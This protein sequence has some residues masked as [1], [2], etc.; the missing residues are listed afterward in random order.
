MNMRWRQ[1]C[2]LAGAA[3]LSLLVAGCPTAARRPPAAP[4]APAPAAP[5]PQAPPQAQPQAGDADMQRSSA[6][7]ERIEALEGVETA[8][9]V[10]S[11]EEAYVG[12][13]AGAEWARRPQANETLERRV[14]E[15]ALESPLGIKRAYVTTKPELYQSIFNITEG[16]RAGQP[17][18]RF[19]SELN[20]LGGEI[21]PVSLP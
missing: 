8:W 4:P 1:V 16:L 6:L 20:K 18:A 14:A 9:V 10:V 12:V 19:Q 3:T 5:G 11:G 17:M 2:F 13:D 15:A 21:T 7:M